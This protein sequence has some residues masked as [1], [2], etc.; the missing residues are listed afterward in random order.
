MNNQSLLGDVRVLG[1]TV[2]L[3]GP[4]TLLNLA[5]LGAESIKVEVPGSG[6]PTRQNGPFVT[7]D[8]YFENQESDHH[9]ST[10][11]I[12]RSEG[13]KSITL[14]LKNPKGKQ[15]F[16]ELAKESDVLVE[17]LAPGAMKRLGLGFEDVIKENPEIIYA[18][19]SGYGQTGPYSKKRAQDPQIQG[20]SGLMDINGYTDGP[21]TKV[22]FL[23]GDLVTPLFACY[24]ILAALRQKE[25]TGEG[26]YLDVSM[27]DTLTSLIMMDTLEEDLM[28]GEPVRMGNILR[29]S[30]SG[31]FSTKDGEITITAA[32]D[33]Q[34]ANLSKALNA[35]E[36][37][38]NPEFSTFFA[39]NK[40]IDKAVASIQQILSKFTRSEALERL[41]N[42]GIPCGPVRSVEEVIKDQHYWDR[43]TLRNMKNAAFKDSVPGISTGFPVKFSGVELPD[44]D[45]APTLGMHN[46]EIFGELLN[47]DLETINQ[48]KNDGVI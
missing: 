39:R 8:G 32:S 16:L 11:F 44:S 45:G 21:P 38:E 41:E 18:S 46:E 27:M 37:V 7:P 1:V 47:L 28:N 19:I 5:R 33:D 6:D 10:R 24:S 3:A 42:G 43:G 2:F 12:K 40:N 9:L 35:P 17:N 30:P 36:L 29:G 34:W 20:M 22:G 25:K 14:N 23:I 4:Y 48:L 26:Q 15:M 13:L 31:N